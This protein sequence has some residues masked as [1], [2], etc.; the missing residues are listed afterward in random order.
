[1]GNLDYKKLLE[2]YREH[3]KYCEGYDFVRVMSEEGSLYGCGGSEV[4]FSKEEIEFM[5]SLSSIES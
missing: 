2:K 3:V 5:E 1:M 4:K